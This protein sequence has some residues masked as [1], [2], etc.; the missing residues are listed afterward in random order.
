MSPPPPWQSLKSILTLVV[1][2]F[3]KY[4]THPHTPTH[5]RSSHDTLRGC[6][7]GQKNSDQ[8]I[9]GRGCGGE[10]VSRIAIILLSLTAVV[11]FTRFSG[12][13]CDSMF[14][15]LRLR[16]KVNDTTGTGHDV[17]STSFLSLTGNDDQR[18]IET[19]G[20][21]GERD[22]YSTWLL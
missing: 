13:Q 11:R 2:G 5:T 7:F 21:M 1:V 17:L 9:K 20:E 12:M 16:W 4:H 19:G 3:I 18:A 8:I 14:N 6:S 22:E 15:H 10:T